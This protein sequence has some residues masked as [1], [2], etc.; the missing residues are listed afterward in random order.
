MPFWV[1]N[2]IISFGIHLVLLFKMGII[3][4]AYA[5]LI[6]HVLLLVSAMF[7]VNGF[8]KD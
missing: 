6:E 3:G 2:R 7:V 4:L 5:K 8:F 1:L